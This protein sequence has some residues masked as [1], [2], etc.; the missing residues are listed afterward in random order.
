MVALT[1]HYQMHGISITDVYILDL[2]E[3]LEPELYSVSPKGSLYLFQNYIFCY[4][5][6][7]TMP[8]NRLFPTLYNELKHRTK[9]TGAPREPAGPGAP[10]GPAGPWDK[11]KK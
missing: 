2:K 6:F 3:F 10:A 7:L 1:L 5:L 9:L 4:S 11:R 8:E